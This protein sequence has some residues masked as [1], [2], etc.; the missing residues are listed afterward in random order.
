M[1]GVVGIEPMEDNVVSA[2]IR[3]IRWIECVHLYELRKGL[4]SNVLRFQLGMLSHIVMELHGD[5]AHRGFLLTGR[6]PGI[7]W[8]C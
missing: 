7:P 8:V 3:S 5:D 1:I 4:K 6:N 2:C